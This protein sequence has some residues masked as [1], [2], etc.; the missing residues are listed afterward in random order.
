MS[1]GVTGHAA[2][3]VLD[4]G[5]VERE[6]DLAELVRA[7]RS[8]YASD[9]PRTAR[10]PARMTEFAS[11]PHRVFGAMPSICDALDLFVTKVVAAVP[12]PG[13]A[14]TIDG[15]VVALSTRSGEPVACVDAAAVTDLKC[16]AVTGLVTDACTPQQVG[17]VG[18][19]GSGALAFCQVQGIAAVREVP[20]W[21]VTSRHRAHAERFAA[22]VRRFLGPG[23]EIAVVD[24]IESALTGH[25]VVCTATSATTPLVDEFTVPNGAH[26]NCMGGHALDSRELPN[27]TLARSLLLVED[28][29][30]A[31]EEAG[32]THRAALE[33]AELAAAD[34]RELRARP[35]VF[36]S[37]GHAF[38]DLLVTSH[39]LRTVL[40]HR[41]AREVA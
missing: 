13:R 15:L 5:R 35:T 1:E 26:V 16:A 3:P 31:V 11:D 24:D 14:P 19:V 40:G 21:T 18:I 34:G 12:T 9:L 30:I 33:L 7:L 10:T 41:A 39:V 6:T 38:L 2:P 8:A 36:S 37:T 32:E 22:R 28:R 4:R 29:R 27:G 25:D 20:R 17:S 23:A